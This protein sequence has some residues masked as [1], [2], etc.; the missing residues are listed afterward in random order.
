MQ[1]RIRFV[2]LALLALAA[3]AAA[4][5]APKADPPPRQDDRVERLLDRV[6]AERIERD[7]RRL[8]RFGTR[9]TLSSR[10]DPE[11]GIGAAERWVREEFERI[12]AG[13]GGRLRVETDTFTVPQSRR[14]PRPA[15]VANVAALLPGSEPERLVLVSG[16]LDSRAS[17]V[18]D[19]ESDAPGAN[20]DASGVA[21][22]LELARILASQ[23]LRA[24]VLFVAFGGEE[25]GTLGST[26][27]AESAKQ[28]GRRVEALLNNDIIGNTRGPYGARDDRRVRIFSEGLPSAEMP[29]ETRRR[30][31]A[32]GENDSP[33]RQLARAVADV[34]RRYLPEFEV[35]LV[36][37][38]DRLLRGGDHTPFNARGFAAVR[39]TEMLEDWRRQHQDVRNRDGVQFGD[40]PQFVDFRYVAS[41]TRLNLAA[42]AEL[43]WASPPPT[44]VR[45]VA[46]LEADTTLRWEKP[47]DPE[48][49]GYEVLWRP[50][51]TSWAPARPDW[52]V[53]RFVGD[54]AEATLQVPKDDYLFAV[55]AV[56]HQGNRG[57]PTFAVPGRGN[58]APPSAVSPREGTL[59]RPAAG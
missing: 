9:H 14:I 38:R 24:T 54:V 7:V 44:G 30:A 15:E 25:Q 34:Q 10:T 51:P 33:S 42:L 31:S 35:S 57:L 12:A 4:A 11:R 46:R 43:A 50:L 6:S 40:L 27:W 20:D 47:E 13:T 41:V 28:Q 23:Q 29:E 36:F 53:A 22:V 55:R 49:A 32:G 26:R 56:T 19:G 18:L 3:A 2:A 48:R 37:R 1:R 5:G 52:Q 45:L 16:H 39:F 58:P 8:A 59:A 17:N 21:A